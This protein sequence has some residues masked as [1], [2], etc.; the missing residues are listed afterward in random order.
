MQVFS[1]ISTD[2]DYRIAVFVYVYGKANK[3]LIFVMFF[4]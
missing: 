2:S 1:P 3:A 4:S